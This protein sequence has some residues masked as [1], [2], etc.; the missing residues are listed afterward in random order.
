MYGGHR[1]NGRE[2]YQAIYTGEA[3]DRIPLS[4][5]GCWEET[6]ER[7]RDEGLHP[8]KD[9]NDALGLVSED[10]MT[11]EIDLNMYPR[12]DM[13]VREIGERYVTVVDEHGVTKRMLRADYDRSQGSMAKAGATSSMSHWIAFPVT[14][15]AAN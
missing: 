14:F 4:R 9:P 11:L 1:M 13:A 15:E 8:D 7:W 2:L 12:F 3:F 6:L 5:I 10:T